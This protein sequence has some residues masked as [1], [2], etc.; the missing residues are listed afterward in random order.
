MVRKGRNPAAATR[1][2]ARWLRSRNKDQVRAWLE[3]ERQAVEAQ[4]A[5]LQDPAIAWTAWH[6]EEYRSLANRKAKIIV[7]E[8]RYCRQEAPVRPF[9]HPYYW[10]PVAAP[11]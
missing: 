2:A 9:A 3:R 8:S 7:A 1:V 4:L 6:E 11:G 10:A 5:S